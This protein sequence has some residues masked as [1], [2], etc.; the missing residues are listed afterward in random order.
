MTQADTARSAMAEESWTALGNASARAA[1]TPRADRL[2]ADPLA[3][4]FLAAVEG[5]A[6]AGTAP[7]SDRD[8]GAAARPPVPPPDLMRMIGDSIVVKTRFFDDFFATA[9]AAGCRQAVLLAAGLDTRA[10]RL[11]WPDRLRL[12]EADLPGLFDFKEAV[13][14]AAAARP[15]CDRVVVR[16]DLRDDWPGALRA[17]GLDPD[18]PTAW[19]AEG[20]LGFLTPEACDRVLGGV[21]ALSAPGSRLGLDHTH[22]GAVHTPHLRPILAGVGSSIDDMIKGGPEVPA[23][24]W[25]ARHGWRVEVHDIVE[26]AAAYGR[27]APALFQGERAGHARILHTAVRP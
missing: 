11:P 17:S 22:D 13:L 3:E 19:L 2:F 25:L 21:N 14:G 24:Q 4:R 6:P 23:D 15:T 10:F 7:A 26:R 16:T 5:A 12:F 9:C 27:P 20:M 18:L 1:E 8:P